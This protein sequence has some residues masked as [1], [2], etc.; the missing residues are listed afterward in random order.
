MAKL[1]ELRKG[2]SVRGVLRNDVVSVVDSKWDGIRCVELMYKSCQ[3]RLADEHFHRDREA[4]L[5]SVEVGEG[6][7]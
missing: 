3:G 7:R 2:A 6:R 4:D 1:E 5:R